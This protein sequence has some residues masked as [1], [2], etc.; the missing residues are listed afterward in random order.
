ML[1]AIDACSLYVM[2]WDG[3]QGHTKVLDV[4]QGLGFSLCAVPPDIYC[5]QILDKGSEV[6]TRSS[7]DNQC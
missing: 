6:W 1:R 4:W 2:S 3:D 7:R 5:P